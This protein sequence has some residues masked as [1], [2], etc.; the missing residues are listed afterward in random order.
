MS[1]YW[2]TLRTQNIDSA[3]QNVSIPIEDFDDMVKKLS[4]PQSSLSGLP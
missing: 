2:E 4:A 3:Q 1:T